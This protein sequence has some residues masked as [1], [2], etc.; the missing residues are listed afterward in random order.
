MSADLCDGFM[1]SAK[2]LLG[3]FA[4][5]KNE[6]SHWITGIDRP[7]LDYSFFPWRGDFL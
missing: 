5:M 4:R 3:I 1:R 2:Y 7:L 6:D